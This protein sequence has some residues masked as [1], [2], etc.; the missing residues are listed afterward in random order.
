[1]AGELTGADGAYKSRQEI[2]AL[3]A[4]RGVDLNR[5]IICTCGF[6][7]FL[8]SSSF[9][10]GSLAGA[11][12]VS[13]LV[14]ELHFTSDIGEW[15]GS[16]GLGRRRAFCSSPSM[17]FSTSE[18]SPCMMAGTNRTSLSLASLSLSSLACSHRALSHLSLTSL[19]PLSHLSPRF[20]SLQVLADCCACLSL[21]IRSLRE[22]NCRH[23]D[24]SHLTCRSVA[25]TST[26]QLLCP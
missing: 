9:Y 1:M 26:A 21:S 4:K 14:L 17:P 15:F 12:L 23:L 22:I 11:I 10:A 7:F 6:F 2:E 5:H 25:L 16:T 18:T 20:L 3:L 8:F 24:L 19:S 13:G